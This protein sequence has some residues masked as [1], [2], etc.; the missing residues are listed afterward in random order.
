MPVRVLLEAAGDDDFDD[1]S[2]NDNRCKGYSCHV[3]RGWDDIVDVERILDVAPTMTMLYFLLCSVC[4]TSSSSPSPPGQ[5]RSPCRPQSP[6]G[7]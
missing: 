7:R 6:Y 5:A 1:E 2:T 3:E 4:I